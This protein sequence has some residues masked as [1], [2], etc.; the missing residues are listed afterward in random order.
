MHF[1]QL[2]RSSLQ[3][4]PVANEIFRFL[5]RLLLVDVPVEGA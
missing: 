3:T 4:M 5:P 2:K 1:L